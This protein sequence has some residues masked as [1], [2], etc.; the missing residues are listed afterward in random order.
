VETAP[1][2]RHSRGRF[3]P[4]LLVAGGAV[5]GQIQA[6]LKNARP[7][8]T[9]SSIPI[10]A[11]AFALEGGAVWM[12]WLAKERGERGE[13]VKPFFIASTCFALVA[14][15]V[16]IIGHWGDLWSLV[17]FGLLS[18]GGYAIWCIDLN[19]LLDDTWDPDGSIRKQVPSIRILAKLTTDADL[20][21][22]ARRLALLYAE[23]HRDKLGLGPAEAIEMA[24]KERDEQHREAMLA[25]AVK[26]HFEELGLAQTDVSL[27]ILANG[28]ERIV[29]DLMDA[30][31]SKETAH[32][33][34][35]RISAN[36]L[37]GIVPPVTAPLPSGGSRKASGGRRDKPSESAAGGVV[38]EKASAE[39]APHTEVKIEVKA[40]RASRA[41]TGENLADPYVV[42]GDQLAAVVAAI[43]GWETRENKIS[44]GDVLKAQIAAQ[45]AGTLLNP[46]TSKPYCNKFGWMI[47]ALSERADR[48]P[49]HHW[50]QGG[51]LSDV[52]AATLDGHR[53]SFRSMLLGV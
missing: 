24:I 15:A 1:P 19:A 45:A 44:A 50:T 17:V 36:R 51:D 11:L 40:A 35:R 37:A 32:A 20:V 16:N 22:R 18:A 8:D 25:A 28:A 43:P 39:K 48:I 42:Y 12:A 33:L 6:G 31:D 52:D 5:Y 4:Y 21:R 27:A 3:I 46:I 38:P 23:A 2:R 29:R 34:A 9:I 47:E 14:C 53:A 7:P 13:S 30:V 26:R 41:T 10:F 49:P